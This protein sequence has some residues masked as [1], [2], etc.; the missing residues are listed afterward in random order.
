MR[1][2][3]K[4]VIL[5]ALAVALAWWVAGL[6]GTVAI[7]VG[8]Y[9]VETTTPVAI[10]L[11]SIAFLVLYLVVRGLGLLF[12][13]PR[14]LKRA[15]ERRHRAGGDRAVTRAL[16]AL[17][18]NDPDR[19]QE[20]AARS[21]RLL[22][23]TPLTLLLQGQAYRQAGREHEAE[24][25]FQQLTRVK[26][27]ALLGHRGLLQ[28][29]TGKGDWDT[30]NA[31]ALGA[32]AAY[33]GASWV[34]QE[35]KQLALRTGAY[36]DAL[37]LA[38]DEDRAGLAI[39]AA[40]AEADDTEALR[41]AKQAFNADPALT[42]AALAYATRLRKAGREKAA[43][44][45]LRRAWV[46][47]PHPDL[48]AEAMA[49]VTDKLKRVNAAKALANANPSHP[50]SMLLLAQAAL[51]A[52]LTA[53]AR[54]HAA[55]AQKAGLKQ[56]RLFVLMA[57]IAEKDGQGAEAQE[58][59]RHASTAEPDPVWRCG[60]CA[61]VHGAW[62]PVCPACSTP[63]KIAW[64]QPDAQAPVSLARIGTAVEGITG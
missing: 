48:A 44:D 39:A 51:D 28:I 43:L 23:A 17:A 57:D 63:G 32:E 8:T 35:R 30:A 54:Q 3:I 1:A 7:T 10:L 6:T 13:A 38:G 56:R 53:E 29:A 26:G 25:A 14:R 34:R 22:G 55:A 61:S 60:Q 40:D 15:N 52:G 5:A 42:P 37:R 16:V 64:V 36:R 59:W 45:V 2:V 20:E 33:P 12:S 31:A 24:A 58:A 46:K 21:A 11:A 19:A 18:A 27:G 50:E 47:Q 9:A 49:P 41:L 62:H 4:F